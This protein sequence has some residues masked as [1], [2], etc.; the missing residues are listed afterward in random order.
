[1]NKIVSIVLVFSL[2]LDTGLGATAFLL[3]KQLQAQQ[4]ELTVKEMSIQQLDVQLGLAKSSL[5]AEKDL[6]GQ[7]KSEIDA[8]PDKLKKIID[9]YKLQ[10][11]SRD[12]TIAQLTS[13]ITGGQTDV[14]VVANGPGDPTAPPP[15]LT[16]YKISYEW[17]DENHRFHLIDKN[18]F[19]KGDETF[20]ANQYLAVKGWVF[21]GKDGKLQVKKVEI[22]EVVVTGQ[23]KDGKP[24]YKSLP[25]SEVKVVDSQFEYAALPVKEKTVLDMFGL[26]VFASYDTALTPGIGVEVLNL[27]ELVPYANVGLAGELNVDLS[28]PM[29]GSLQKSRIGANL[30]YKLLKPLADTN[31]GLGIGISTPADDFANKW[32]LTGDVLFYLNN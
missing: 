1:V 5:V 31:L 19:N 6:A 25:N 20:Q 9:K 29:K 2:L 16:R 28:N 22:S 11:Q 27:G 23:D 15:D 17:Q 3:F 7:Y 13:K 32:V 4:A 8:F 10:L 12:S 14:T 18:I 24:L 26:K 21:A 30:T